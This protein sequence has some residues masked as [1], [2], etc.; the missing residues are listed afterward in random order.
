MGENTLRRT[1]EIRTASLLGRQPNNDGSGV[2]QGHLRGN[3][4][5]A[6]QG[7]A[8]E[9]KKEKKASKE[10]F[11]ATAFAKFFFGPGGRQAGTLLLVFG[12]PRDNRNGSKDAMNPGNE[13]QAPIGCVETDNTRTDPIQ[14]HRPCQQ[15]FCKRCIMSVSRREQKEER[16]ARTATDE[17]MHTKASQQRTRM[18][19]GRVSKGSI[20][21]TTSPGQDGS[22]IN[23]EITRSNEASSER[24]QHEQDK[25]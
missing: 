1:D 5:P 17:G 25:Q 23:D 10:A 8:L 19:S 2:G 21:I 22:T 3:L 13:A 9:V 7:W 14:T 12:I 4:R 16:Q 24:L 6:T 11:D 18:V 20:G 15:L